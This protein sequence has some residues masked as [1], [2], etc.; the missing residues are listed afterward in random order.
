M[1]SVD[2]LRAEHRRIE[3][4]LVA[5]EA[6]AI[7]VDASGTIPSF[8]T[9]LLDFFQM[10]ADVG[11]HAKEEAFLFPMMARHGVGP[12]GTVD[13]MTHQHHLGR[14]HT[15]DM[16]TAI[17]RLRVGDAAA[18]PAFVT[19]AHAYLEL[20]RVHIAIEDGDL[21]PV[22]EELLTSE[23]D[24]TLLREFL[25]VDG[26]KEAR[27]QQTRWGALVARIHEPARH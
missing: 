4:M 5:L 6:A 13:A 18:R 7:Q 1:K 22:A 14:L 11:H 26:S 23:E 17:D 25:E 27:A 3:E 15:R 10:F 21:Y 12:T 9:D 16:R 19:S 2:Y 20:L 8:I 24:R